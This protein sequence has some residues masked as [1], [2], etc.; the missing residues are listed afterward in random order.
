MCLMGPGG[1]VVRTLGCTVTD[2][3]YALSSALLTWLMLMAAAELHTPTWTKVGAK[4]AVGNR[5]ALPPRSPIAARADRAAK[6]MIENMV[7]FV[8]VFAA[9]KSTG[10]DCTVGAAIFFHARVAYF[11]SY[12][13]GI[14]VVRSLIWGASLVGLFWMAQSAW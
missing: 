12:L 3:H 13:A 4:L 7:L 8:C 5:D 14:V 11:I 1:G 9:V 6:N 10:A 2:V